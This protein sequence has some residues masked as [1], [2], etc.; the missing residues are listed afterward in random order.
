MAREFWYIV[1]SMALAFV[2][3]LAKVG[4]EQAARMRVMSLPFTFIAILVAIFWAARVSA[5]KADR[6]D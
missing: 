4:F 5:E 1:I 6:E 2:P 3:A